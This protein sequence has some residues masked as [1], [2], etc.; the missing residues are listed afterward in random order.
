MPENGVNFDID[1]VRIYTVTN[2]RTWG[3]KSDDKNNVPIG[4]ESV[5]IAFDGEMDEESITGK[6]VKLYDAEEN[7]LEYNAV[8]DKKTFVYTITP[9]NGF[10]S[11]KYKICVDKANI[12]GI[13]PDGEKIFGL[14][15]NAKELEEFT[16]FNGTLPEVKN[17]YVSGRIEVGET[18]KAN[19]EYYQAEGISGET[20][21]EWYYSDS[22]NGEYIKIDG[23][24]SRELSVTENLCDKYVKISAYAVTNDGVCGK[25]VSSAALKPLLK[26]YVK[27]VKI[28]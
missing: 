2:E 14:S 10:K 7:E 9:K 22:E 28:S 25:Q 19:A 26:P 21:I 12:N 8:Y 23:A 20:K 24:D 11:G 13:K 27:D 1:N 6:T 16:V 3:I 18:L 15:D 17:V 5:E 4:K